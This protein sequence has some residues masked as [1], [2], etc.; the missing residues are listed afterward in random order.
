M[1]PKD[2]CLVFAVITPAPRCTSLATSDFAFAL[3]CKDL[4]GVVRQDADIDWALQ[5]ALSYTQEKLSSAFSQASSI[6]TGNKK[7]APG[8]EL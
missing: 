3:P 2:A 7:A 1:V 4:T 6:L 5:S 8:A